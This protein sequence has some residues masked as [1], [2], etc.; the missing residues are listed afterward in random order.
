MFRLRRFLK[1][2]IVL[3]IVGPLCKLTE[4]VLELFIPLVTADIINNGVL[5]NDASYVLSHGALMV[6]MEHWVLDLP[7]YARNR[8]Q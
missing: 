3:L 7:L 2:Y 5:K 1:D 8:R 4:A 6:L